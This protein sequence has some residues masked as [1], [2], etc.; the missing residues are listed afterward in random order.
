DRTGGGAVSLDE[1]LVGQVRADTDVLGG[2]AQ[3]DVADGRSLATSAVSRVAAAVGEAGGHR[4]VER[5]RADHDVADRG[6]G[7]ASA[8]AG[9]VGVVGHTQVAGAGLADVDGDRADR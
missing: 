5:R 9:G 6:R 3:G 1:V 4:D 2:R 7:G 8:G